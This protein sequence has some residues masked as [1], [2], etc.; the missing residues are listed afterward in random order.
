MGNTIIFN[1][2]STEDLGLVIQA[3]PSYDFPRKDY[4]VTHVPGRSGDIVI[5]KGSYQN[6][7]RTYYLASA[8][9]PGIS[10]IT[11]AS[12]IV[13][14]LTSANGYARLED[15]YEPEYFRLAMFNSD[16]SM[17][18]YYNQATMI[19]V[20]FECKP[21]RYLKS[22]ELP[23]DL[24]GVTE[25]CID[26][27]TNYVSLPEITIKGNDVKITFESNQTKSAVTINSNL[28]AIIDSELQESYNSEKL[29]NN[30]T[31]LENGFPKLYP[32]SNIIKIEG[33]IEKLSIKPRWW[34]L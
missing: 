10:F 9:K 25:F 17:Q 6:S 31:V 20:S 23:I 26:N 16:G 28:E 3:P 2:V 1:G 13:K 19:N 8:F 27:P 14:W 30:V 15:S 24:S 12:E 33:A 32:G 34:I 18:N 29:L 11:N 7:K 21:Q 4:E 22:G 5:D